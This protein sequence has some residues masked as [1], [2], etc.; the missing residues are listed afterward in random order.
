MFDKIVLVTRKT[1]LSELIER[2]N[3]K[4]QAKFYIE[5]SG[6]AFSEY[7]EEDRVY[8]EALA[9]LNGSLDFDMPVQA[10]DR[11][12]VPTFLFGGNDLV[13]MAGAAAHISINRA[14]PAS[15]T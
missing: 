15:G 2:F 8:S 4:S 12:F 9:R 5:R 7:E 1:R 13:V 11:S 3:S 6:A 14:W 10:I